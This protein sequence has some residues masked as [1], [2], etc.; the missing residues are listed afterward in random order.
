MLSLCGL[1]LSGGRE[2]KKFDNK[3][4]HANLDCE[5]FMEFRGLIGDKSLIRREKER[6]RVKLQ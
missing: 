4:P 6:E 1:S 3:T 5:K 2:E